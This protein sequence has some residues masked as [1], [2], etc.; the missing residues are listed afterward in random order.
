M[1]SSFPN[2]IIGLAIV[3]ASIL[4]ANA[5]KYKFKSSEIISVT[6]IAEKNFTSDLIVWKASF[7]RK[8]LLLKDAYTLIK[9]DEDEIRA[10]LKT[11][12]VTPS[13]TAF[14]S[15]T[16][17]K[18]FSDNFDAKGNK[19]NP[20]F[21]GYKLSE[22]VS[23]ESQQIDKIEKV[24][25]EVTQ[26]V[27]NGI[28]INSYEPSYYYTKLSDLKIDLLAKASADAKKRA[29]T[30]AENSGSSLGK[31]RSAAMGVFQITGQN[32]NE[33]YSEGGTFNTSSINK[34][35]TITIRIEYGVK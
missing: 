34:K 6:G 32:S 26:L 20:T 23:V 35:A 29:E 5:Y 16:I 22:D 11:K 13:E 3:I 21:T 9:K 15:I 12:N 30:I 24:S 18:E 28:E 2:L 4:F 17:T 31:I 25:R 19:I 7:E 10:Y 14:S 8:T 33:A 1:K 27:E